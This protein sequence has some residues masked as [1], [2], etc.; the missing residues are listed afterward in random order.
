MKYFLLKQDFQGEK[1]VRRIHCEL[2][3]LWKV[4]ISCQNGDLNVGADHIGGESGAPCIYHTLFKD[5]ESEVEVGP[6]QLSA[7]PSASVSFYYVCLS[8]Y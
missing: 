2:S 7:Y 8:Q 6:F 3:G 4:N 1:Y 5:M